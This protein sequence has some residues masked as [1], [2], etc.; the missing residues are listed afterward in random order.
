MA[1][2]TGTNWVDVLPY[3]LLGICTT[4]KEDLQCSSAELVFGIKLRVSGDLTLCVPSPGSSLFL[5]WLQN[6]VAIFKR[7]KCHSMA[8]KYIRLCLMHSPLAILYFSSGTA[9]Y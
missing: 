3:V 8:S 2:L 6:K 7:S 9:I 1:Q 5:P 4:P